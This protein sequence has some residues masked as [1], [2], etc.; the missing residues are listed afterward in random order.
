MDDCLILG[1]GVVGLSLAYE[2]AGCGLKVR[3]VERGTPGREASWAGAGILPPGTLRSVDHPYDQ[4]TGLSCGLHPEWSTALREETGVDN[5]YRRC[6]GLHLAF[7]PPGQQELDRQV[8]AWQ[9]QGVAVEA[10]AAGQLASIDAQID[11]GPPSQRTGPAYW[12]PGEAQIRN[13][14]HLKA[15]ESACA[16]RGVVIQCGAAAE[17]FEVRDGR[18]RGLVTAAGSYS[19]EA[20]CVAGGAWSRPFLAELMTAAR[21]RIAPVRGQ[22]LLL[23][24]RGPRLRGIVNV[25]PRYLVP[26][27]D[28]RV[29]VGSTEEDVGFDKRTTA[30]GVEGLFRFALR[31]APSLGGAEFERSWAGLRPGTADR[32]PYLGRVPGHENAFVATGHFRSGLTLSPATA[33]VMSQLIRGETP[34]VNLE[35][36]RL[37]R[38]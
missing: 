37:D 31:L 24:T 21:P 8:A 35:P 28:G 29:L 7:D 33:V 12:L 34:A 19:A 6:G 5:G 25:G 9:E 15:L 4:L 17:R 36:F 23:A 11:E 20:Y 32:L 1:A 22:M 13:P 30:A 27:P 3:V 38:P 2:L 10:I 16:R 14:R 26:R 18:V